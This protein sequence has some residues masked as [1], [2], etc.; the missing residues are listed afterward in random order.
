MRRPLL[1][2]LACATAL[3][4]PSTRSSTRWALVLVLAVGS[5][6]VWQEV[7]RQFLPGSRWSDKNGLTRGSVNTERDDS[8]SLRS[9]AG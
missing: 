8:L 7:S 4:T 1:V 5:C 3:V 6:T 2:A 9:Q